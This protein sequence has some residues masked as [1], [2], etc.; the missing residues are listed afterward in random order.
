MKKVLKC[1]W[2]MDDVDLGLLIPATLPFAILEVIIVVMVVEVGLGHKRPA[3]LPLEIMTFTFLV[4]M[5]DVE[6]SLKRPAN[7]P[8]KHLILKGEVDI[9]LIPAILSCVSK[10]VV[11]DFWASHFLLVM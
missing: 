5:V 8:L 2:V 6:L 3:T 1:L 7:F 10:E 11:V 9:G 4:L